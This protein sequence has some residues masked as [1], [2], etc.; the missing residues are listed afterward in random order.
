MFKLVLNTFFAKTVSALCNL[1][2]AIFISK[3]LGAEAKGETSILLTNISIVLLFTNVFGGGT[4]AFLLSKYDYRKIFNWFYIVAAAISTVFF[5]LFYFS[6]KSLLFS[7]HCAVLSFIVAQFAFFQNIFTCLNKIKQLNFLVVL[8]SVLLF[9]V[10]FLGLIIFKKG[11]ETYTAGLYISYFFSL[12]YSVYF[13]QKNKYELKNK[14]EIINF[15]GVLKLGIQ[16]QL[17]HIFYL[18]LMRFSYYLLL[19]NSGKFSVGVF[20]NAIIIAE[21]IWLVSSSLATVQYAKIINSTLEESIKVTLSFCRIGFI[22]SIFLIAFIFLLPN[23]LF[24]TFFGNDFT[25]VKAIVLFLAPGIVVYNFAIIIGHFFSGIGHFKINTT[26][27]FVGLIIT[28][29]SLLFYYS[30]FSIYYAVLFHNVA[31]FSISAVLV[32]FFI[33]K[34]NIKI[35]SIFYNSNDLSYFKEL[36]KKR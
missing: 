20:S 1:L 3:I 17:S 27:N 23:T 29:S 21:G 15:F 19:W 12:I 24:I 6:S 4:I 14:T 8:Q 11:I 31:Y 25:E 33:S 13:F 26:A 28:V 30:N 5:I 32:C 34:N 18:F 2:V 22:V 35:K 16:N 7:I 9:L 36:F 10:V